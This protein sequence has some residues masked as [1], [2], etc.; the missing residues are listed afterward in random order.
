MGFVAEA[1]LAL[2]REEN[3]KLPVRAAGVSAAALLDQT[4]TVVQWPNRP[5]W[6]G[7]GLRKL[8]Q[9]HL[10]MQI[11]IEDDANAAALAEAVLGAGQRYQDLLVMTVGTGVGAGLILNKSLFSGRNG[12]AGELGHLIMQRDG[13]ACP[14]GKRGCLQMLASGRT[15]ERIAAARGLNGAEAVTE[16]AGRGETWAV[17]ALAES[18]RW[19]GLAAANVVDLLDLQAVI[20]GG[21]LSVLGPPW[22]SS[23]EE[24]CQ[25]SLINAAHKQV[26]LH[27][28]ALGD[29][30]GLLGAVLL[31][32]QLNG[33]TN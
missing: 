20:V 18:G 27:R 21:G 26:A 29:T 10:G 11:V 8:L 32:Q 30:A 4:G 14:C 9:E 1:A 6:R 28:A 19:L 3:L 22:W 25:S 17:E 2:V 15:L 23:L 7:L 31:A 24:T 16:A 13:P 5:A 12:W 33:E